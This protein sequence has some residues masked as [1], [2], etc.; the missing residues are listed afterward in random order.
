MTYAQGIILFIVA[1][2]AG[3]LWMHL[4][5]EDRDVVGRKLLKDTLKAV[6]IAS[7]FGSLGL[8]YVTPKDVFTAT[9]LFLALTLCFSLYSWWYWHKRGL[10]GLDAFALGRWEIP[11]AFT[12]SCVAAAA[13]LHTL[14]LTEQPSYRKTEGIMLLMMPAV[15]PILIPPAVYMAYRYWNKIPIVT[16]FYEAWK[17]PLGPP[18]VIEPTMDSRRLYFT[19]PIQEK[20]QRVETFD[21]QVANDSTL[22]AILHHMLYEYN[23]V[24]ERSPKISVAYLDKKEFIYG[25]LIYR[26]RR[27]WWFTRKEYFDMAEKIR[28]TDVAPGETL[29]AERVRVWEQV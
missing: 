16:R 23:I 3:V 10:S 7:V 13:C 9:T 18:P 17:L 20:S 29:F 1:G 8:L 14:Y 12:L 15:L 24:Y 22:S 4:A 11:Q 26:P 27:K 19:I 5:R 6:V 21:V 28:F 25:W 2:L